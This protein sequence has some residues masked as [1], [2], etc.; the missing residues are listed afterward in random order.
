MARL[1]KQ[2]RLTTEYTG[3]FPAQLSL[4]RRQAILD[5]ACGPGEWALEVA[6]KYP[7]CQVTGVDISQIMTEYARYMAREQALYNVEF[8][9]MD[10]RKALDFP[11]ASFDIVHA[12]FITGFMSPALW[13]GLLAE[14]FR[15]LRPGGV[16]CSTEAEVGSVTTGLSFTR[17]TTLMVQAMQMVGQSFTKEGYNLGITAMQARLLQQAGFQP[18]Q[19]QA[20]VVNFS[21]GMP[22]HAGALADYQAMLKLVQ[23]FLLHCHLATQQELDVLYLRALDDLQ[24]E[25]F[26]GVSFLQTVWGEKPH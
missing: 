24:A 16:M 9:V 5:L 2:A 18:I 20:H 8:Q 7:W 14:C 13:S 26:N 15:V 1:V 23:P 11:D 4:N 25:D 10:A 22:A 6:R 12:R 19:Q 3:L 21:A 17:Y